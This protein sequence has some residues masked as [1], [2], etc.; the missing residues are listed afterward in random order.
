MHCGSPGQRGGHSAGSRVDIWPRG[1][2]GPE[3]KEPNRVHSVV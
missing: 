1:R 3:G 2:F